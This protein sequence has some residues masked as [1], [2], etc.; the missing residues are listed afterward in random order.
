MQSQLSLSGRGDFQ[1]FQGATPRSQGEDISPWHTRC[2][3]CDISMQ[4]HLSLIHCQCD[5]INIILI[6]N[7]KC[8]TY[9]LLGKK[10]IIAKLGY[11]P[12]FYSLSCSFLLPL[13]SVTFASLSDPWWEHK[14]IPSHCSPILPSWEK[15]GEK[16]YKIT[17]CN[18]S[19]KY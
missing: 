3:Q 13:C 19:Y 10:I 8:S 14:C 1:V 5:V 16:K 12:P 7:G 9:K 17:K 11:L 15:L 2:S 4:E 18:Q 6:I